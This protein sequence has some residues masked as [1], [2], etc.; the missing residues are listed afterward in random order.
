[1][2]P[3][4][5]V[6]AHGRITSV[7]GIPRLLRTKSP[8][9]RLV[10]GVS[11][12]CFL[13]MAA[14][15]A[16]K[17]TQSYFQ[18]S[19]VIS[20][21]E[22]PLIVTGS[23]PNVQLADV[24]FCNINPFASNF[25]ADSDLLSIEDFQ[26]MVRDTTRCDDCTQDEGI[27]MMRLRDEMLTTRGYF[28]EIG[29]DNVERMSH[30]EESLIASCHVWFISGMHPGT[31]PCG[32]V[33][34]VKRYRDSMF[35]N[36]YTIR[37]PAIKQ[38]QTV[39]LGLIIIFHLDMYGINKHPF[40]I[41]VH[42]KMRFLSGLVFNFHEPGSVPIFIKEQ[43]LV[44]SGLFTDFK[45]RVERHRR[46][47]EPYGE[48]VESAGEDNKFSLNGTYSQLVCYSLCKQTTVFDICDCL[49]YN[50][51]V[52]IQRNSSQRACFN[53]ELGREQVMKDW[54]CVQN[55]RATSALSCMEKCPLPCEEIKMETKVNKI[56]KVL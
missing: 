8:F 52:S 16:V 26:S 22:T 42:P 28:V 21:R 39:Y 31:M 29:A 15:Q 18:Y 3:T 19:T 20:I 9:M 24:T 54:D 56:M 11:I 35:Y 10:W 49:D 46:L 53:M 17:L 6:V 1:M 7:K 14:W 4:G 37:P 44:Q 34:A 23:S 13:S 41:A 32:N 5:K 25:S 27:S 43:L 48:C 33:M 12:L 2:N 40:P 47:S 45:V 50:N 30:T 36:C 55:A 51:F 38:E